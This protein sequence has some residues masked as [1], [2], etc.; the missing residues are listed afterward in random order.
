MKRR[1]SSIFAQYSGS[2]LFLL[3]L[4]VFAFFPAVW[5]FATSIKPIT[6][7][8][9]VPPRFTSDHP[10]LE[11]YRRVIFE[12]K[13][14]RAFL[15]SVII[16]FCTTFMTLIIS[17]LAGYGFARY[18]FS[19]SRALS[20]GL[21]F[22]QM[23]PG[24]IIIMPLYMIFNKIHLIDTYAAVI[25]ANMAVTIPM[26]VIMLRS[27]FQTV[28]RELEEAAKIDGASSLGALF[29]II[30]PISIPG[31]IAVGVNSFLNSWE[32]FLFALNLTHS[33]SVK[34]L[35]IAVNEFSGEFVVDWGG[36]MSASVVIS[37]P[38][39]LIFLLCNKYF[40]KGLSDGAVKG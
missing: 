9:Q 19:G 3:F 30:L 14:P 24:V 37:V 38:V 40:V 4:I 18:R 16:T 23:M 34:T 29:R 2:Y 32:E 13:I 6:E 33:E 8:F 22:G 5:M 27:F 17:I 36:M 21:L 12:S 1:R 39:L 11:N 25:I 28:P 10:T 31:I 20:T 15:N 7:I 26:G 35:P